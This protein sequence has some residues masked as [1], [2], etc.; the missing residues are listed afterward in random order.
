VRSVTVDTSSSRCAEWT[1][2]RG[3]LYTVLPLWIKR[4]MSSPGD[5]DLVADGATMG[6]SAQVVAGALVAARFLPIWL[7]MA[8]LIIVAAFFAPG[9][10]ESTSWS[11][12]LPYGTILAIA[13]LGQMLVVMQAGIDLS[14]AGTISLCGNVL[15]GVSV[16]SDRGLAV[17][18][19]VCIGLGALVGL[20][21]GILV[22]IVRL[23]P[24]IVTLA[25]GQIVLAY[26]SKYAREHTIS[27][28]VPESLSSWA[29]QKPLGISAV[30][31][32]GAA[33]AVALALML[34][35]TAAGRRFQAV[36]ANPRAAWMAGL[37]VRTHV[38]F[39][40]TAAGVLYSFAAILLAGVR[41]TIDPAFGASYLLAPIAAVVLAGAALS[42]G[43]ASATSTWVAAIA[44]TFLTEML[45][46]FGLSAALQ[47]I[48]FGAAIIVGM[49]VSG[50]RVASVLG[51]VLRMTETRSGGGERT[52][53]EVTS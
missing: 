10:L 37:H 4:S 15:V 16:G 5:R 25:V 51:R 35:Y 49:L 9:T 20:V 6:R 7:G 3:W 24:L 33:L 14:T 50:D 1:P 18:I 12:I 41:I 46:I 43:L 39:A 17:G 19:L 31:W 26:S 27:L 21:N 13:A 52:V 11:Y 30:F 8:A 28:Q 32:T 34:R 2:G 47:F 29:A 44:L 38:V 40:Y 36:G 23:N 42:G 22:G 45:L 53:N 48:V